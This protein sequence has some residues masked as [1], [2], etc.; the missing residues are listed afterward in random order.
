MAGE[1]LGQHSVI[2]THIHQVTETS[3][4][5]LVVPRRL[6]NR[7]KCKR[8]TFARSIFTSCRSGAQIGYRL[9]GRSTR[10]RRGCG[11]CHCTA[12]GSESGVDW[13]DQGLECQRCSSLC[14]LERGIAELRDLLSDP[15]G[16][17]QVELSSAK[18]KIPPRR[19]DASAAAITSR[20][21]SVPKQQRFPFLS[22]RTRA[23]RARAREPG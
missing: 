22:P 8:G 16:A 20:P 14:H 18:G 6:M 19:L 11:I 21:V 23:T 9:S 3:M 7:A 12:Q 5:Y 10:G 17:Q 2:V 13:A 4:P 1:R 15:Y